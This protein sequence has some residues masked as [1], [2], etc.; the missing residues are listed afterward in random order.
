LEI[1]TSPEGISANTIYGGKWKNVE[2]KGKR[3]DKTEDE[4][5]KY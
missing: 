1:T 5:V 2:E 3:K 4:G